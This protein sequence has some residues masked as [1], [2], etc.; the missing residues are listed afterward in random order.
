MYVYTKA[1]VSAEKSSAKIP[2]FLKQIYM[3][4]CYVET[5]ICPK[6]QVG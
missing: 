3:G 1:V 2:V 5:K 4:N 6:I